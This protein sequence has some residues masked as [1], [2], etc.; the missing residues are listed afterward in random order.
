M[1]ATLDTTHT[2]P[3]ETIA[4]PAIS[5]PSSTPAVSQRPASFEEALERTATKE[6]VTPPAKA[7]AATTPAGTEPVPSAEAKPAGVPPEER[8]PSI[9][10]NARAKA[11]TDA[12]QA[13]DQQWQEKAGWVLSLPPERQ[14]AAQS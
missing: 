12:I 14:A 8:W 2:A 4:A 9:L 6:P 3:V 11:S 5:E 1:E 7:T 13:R 10:E